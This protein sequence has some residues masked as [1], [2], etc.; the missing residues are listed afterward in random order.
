MKTFETSSDL[1]IKLFRS[2]KRGAILKIPSTVF[3]GAY[4]LSVGFKMKPLGVS[5]FLC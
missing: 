3:R 2:L 5:I 1:H 4:A